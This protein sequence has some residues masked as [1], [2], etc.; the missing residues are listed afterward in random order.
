MSS[1]MFIENGVKPDIVIYDFKIKRQAVDEGTRAVLEG[2]EGKRVQVVNEAG[3][4]TPRLEGSVK[5]ALKGKARKIFVEGEE[6]L[7]TLVVMMHA[8]DGA[9]IAYGQPDA[10]LVL[11]ESSEKMRNKARTIYGK[12]IEV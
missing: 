6:D 1:R 7:A 11:I 8:K 10:G 12:M 9:L 5:L 3:T 4:I 2:F